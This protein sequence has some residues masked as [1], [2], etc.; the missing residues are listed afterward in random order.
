MTW[1][2]ALPVVARLPRPVRLRLPGHPRRLD[3]GLVAGPPGARPGEALGTARSLGRLHHADEHR[4][5]LL[6]IV[7]GIL[8]GVAAWWFN[9][10]WW[11]WVSVALL[12][13]IIAA[14]TP[15]VAIPM[16]GM[17]RG[18]GMPS[19]A[20]VKAGIVPTP[21]DDAALDRLL[22]DRRPAIGSSIA[23][24]GIVL[25]TWLMESKPFLNAVRLTTVGGCHDVR[26]IRFDT[27]SRRV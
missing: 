14:M 25:I 3:G 22:L 27:T 18:L 24:A 10:Q 26:D 20:D 13:G 4:R 17:R 23:I 16:A 2:S 6:L 19:R 11:L 8:V 5:L 1:A 12:V 9:G 15:L 21:V 7:S